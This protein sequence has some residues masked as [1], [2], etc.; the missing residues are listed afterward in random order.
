MERVRPP[1]ASRGSCSG[2]GGCEFDGL[3]G[4]LGGAPGW[5]SRAGLA[6][7]STRPRGSAHRAPELPHLASFLRVFSLSFYFEERNLGA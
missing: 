4:E 3:E 2:G 7:T 5:D 1:R 6:A